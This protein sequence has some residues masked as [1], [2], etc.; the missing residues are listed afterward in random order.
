MTDGQDCTLRAST[1]AG[2]QSEAAAASGI[3]PGAQVLAC[4]GHRLRTEDGRLVL[5]TCGV[6]DGSV[7]CLAQRGAVGPAD[8]DPG[9]VLAAV[10]VLQAACTTTDFAVAMRTL[11][12]LVGNAVDRHNNPQYRR[13]RLRNQAFASRLGDRPG[14]MDALRAFGEQPALYLRSH[15]ARS[16]ILE[17]V[18][19]LAARSAGF[20]ECVDTKG[21]AM[22]LMAPTNHASLGVASVGGLPSPSVVQ[23]LQTASIL[24]HCL[25]LVEHIGKASSNSSALLPVPSPQ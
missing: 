16:N 18:W 5:A 6:V 11:V 23:L 14:G 7:I 21:Q 17:R 3:A 9:A 8:V 4:Q 1:I 10:A 22:L 15:S 24:I 19:R 13:I 2:L 25:L 20:H 12:T